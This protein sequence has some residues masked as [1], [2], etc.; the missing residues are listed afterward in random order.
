[1][2]NRKHRSKTIQDSFADFYELIKYFVTHLSVFVFFSYRTANH[3][4]CLIKKSGANDDL[5]LCWAPWGGGQ[6]AAATCYWERYTLL[7][8]LK[9]RGSPPQA[10]QTVPAA[11]WL[12]S[13][14]FSISVC[15]SLPQSPPLFLCRALKHTIPQSTVLSHHSLQRTSS[16]PNA[17]SIWQIFTGLL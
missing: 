17:Q 1:M 4:R 15:V 13:S 7:V 11:G 12:P 14:F 5:C 16:S 9:D 8:P 3:E 6:W 10:N 2:K